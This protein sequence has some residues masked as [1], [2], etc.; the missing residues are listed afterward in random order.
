[1][2]AP[3]ASCPSR[4]PRARWDPL[5]KRWGEAQGAI[6]A[7]GCGRTG[8][9]RQDEGAGS[10]GCRKDGPAAPAPSPSHHGKSPASRF[11]PGRVRGGGLGA[12]VGAGKE[13]HLGGRRRSSAAAS[14]DHVLHPLA[15]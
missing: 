13:G 14:Q 8:R 3:G 2:G 6:R 1:M 10:S 15:T 4:P 5:G 9:R 12:R 7:A 11:A